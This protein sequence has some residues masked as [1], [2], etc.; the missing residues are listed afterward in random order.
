[1]SIENSTEQKTSK[2]IDFSAFLEKDFNVKAWVNEATSSSRV[3][4]TTIIGGGGGGGGKD[5]NSLKE[6][7]IRHLENNVSI[8]IE[9]LQFI[10]QEISYRLG[11]TVED[12]T[13]SMP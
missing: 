8:L 11:K 6:H 12:V 9:K 2:S 3:K 13:K 7:E 1:M 10:S 4:D 5:E